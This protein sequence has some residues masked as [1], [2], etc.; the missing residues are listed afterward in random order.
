MMRK[1]FFSVIMPAYNAQNTIV[2]AVDS[3]EEQNFPDFEIII[4]DDG[5]QDQTPL[6]VEQLKKKYANILSVRIKNGG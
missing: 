4:V 5:S 2:H 3:L 6:V 1:P